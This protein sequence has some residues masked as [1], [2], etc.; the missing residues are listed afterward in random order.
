MGYRQLKSVSDF[1]EGMITPNAKIAMNS[2]TSMGFTVW[3][4]KDLRKAEETGDW[5]ELL[6][7]AQ[8]STRYFRNQFYSRG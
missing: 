1:Q 3:V 2:G 8:K 7:K 5:S 4:N 6:A